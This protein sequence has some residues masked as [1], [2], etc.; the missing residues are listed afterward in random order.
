MILFVATRDHHE[1]YF[2]ALLANVAAP[3]MVA[4]YPRLLLDGLHRFGVAFETPVDAQLRRKRAKLGDDREL[5]DAVW[6]LYRVWIRFLVRTH[7]GHFQRWAARAD[8][9]A[10]GVWNG[11]GWVQQCVIEA[12]RETGKPVIR[13]ENGLLPGTTTIDANGVNA[14]NSISRDPHVFCDLWLGDDIPL[15]RQRAAQPLVGGAVPARYVFVPFQ[16]DSDSQILQHSPWL[17]DMRALFALLESVLPVAERL[18]IVLLCKEHPGSPFS[19]SDLHARQSPS[20]QFTSVRDT[21]ALID[22]ALGTITINSTAGLESLLRFKP[23]A[24]L[25]DTFYAMP[26]LADQIVNSV[27]LEAWLR[28]LPDRQADH[29]LV[30]GFHHYL[31]SRYCVAGAWQHP[32]AEHWRAVDNRLHELAGSI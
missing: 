10:F 5:P 2:R 28:D 25:G 24:V 29:R 13:F 18:G 17:P 26:G 15:L 19:Y 32:D 31:R 11:N 23:V 27:G 20:L 7:L 1:R 9:S 4:R 14:E 21:P 3:G 12:A 30:N 8:I 16:I 6:A 22:H